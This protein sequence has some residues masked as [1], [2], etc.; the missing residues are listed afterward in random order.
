MSIGWATVYKTILAYL[1]ANLTTMLVYPGQDVPASGT[2][3][4]VHFIG[5]STQIDRISGKQR[6][7]Q[8]LQLGIFSTATGQY[9]IP[10][11][12][13][14]IQTALLRKTIYDAAH[15]IRF[16]E[17]DTTPELG[18]SVEK[19]AQYRACTVQ[20]WIEEL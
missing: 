6:A 13:D 19:I 2:W 7:S 9:V 5:G 12:I 18:N 16:L 11:V 10:T 15:G 14:E 3:I 1:A 4:E 8:M 20:A 17:I